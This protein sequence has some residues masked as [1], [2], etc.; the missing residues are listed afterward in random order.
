MG[1]CHI[2]DIGVMQITYFC[3]GYAWV[4]ADHIAC[5]WDIEWRTVLVEQENGTQAANLFTILASMSFHVM[6]YAFSVG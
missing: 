3:R 2:T 5:A 6:L 4:V 1:A